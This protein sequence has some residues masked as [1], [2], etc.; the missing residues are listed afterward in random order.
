MSARR[1]ASRRSRR[2]LLPSGRSLARQQRQPARLP[3]RRERGP[4]T[5]TRLSKANISRS[6]S[7]APSAR[8]GFSRQRRRSLCS[9]VPPERQ[10]RQVCLLADRPAVMQ[11][12]P[13]GGCCGEVTEELVCEPREEEAPPASAPTSVLLAPYEVYLS[14][15]ISR[16]WGVGGAMLRIVSVSG[17]GGPPLVGRQRGA[18]AVPVRAC[19]GQLPIPQRTT[20]QKGRGGG[21]GPMQ[22][23][24]G[25]DLCSP[26]Y[27]GSGLV[28]LA[29]R[30]KGGHERST[31]H[32]HTH[33]ALGNC[34]G[35]GYLQ[36]S[37]IRAPGAGLTRCFGGRNPRG[38]PQRWVSMA[39]HILLL[40]LVK[41]D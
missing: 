3:T 10:V 15:C 36:T 13:P 4:R 27:L 9:F 18:G 16:P 23:M 20:A 8:L 5:S 39:T 21:G 14:R 35:H 12:P 25:R 40:L 41:T 29:R 7:E 22:H 28:A 19:W 38:S 32:T 37:R 33:T 6:P 11:V 26:S 30:W 31:P 17:L 2:R 34:R 24:N 1:Q